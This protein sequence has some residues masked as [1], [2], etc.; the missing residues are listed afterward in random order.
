MPWHGIRPWLTARDRAVSRPRRSLGLTGLGRSDTE[1]PHHLVVLVLDDV[2]VPD[3]LAGG[4]EGGAHLGD[5]LRVGDHGV[6]APRLAREGGGARAVG[7]EADEPVD[8]GNRQPGR[9]PRPSS[10]GDRLGGPAG[11][12]GAPTPRRCR[13]SYPLRVS[14]EVRGMTPGIM[15]AVTNRGMSLAARV[16]PGSASARARRCP[17]ASTATS[18]SDPASVSRLGDLSDTRDGRRHRAR[19]SVASLVYANE[20]VLEVWADS[21][22]ASAT[23]TVVSPCFIVTM[24]ASLPSTASRNCSCSTRSGSGLL[25]A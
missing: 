4:L 1:R 24:S 21:R 12:A 6:L 16:P 3:V 15:S 5:L 19:V 25:M 22:H 11:R 7:V 20:I 10:R 9:S 2:A 17:V 13:G 8:R 23:R 14:R 18:A